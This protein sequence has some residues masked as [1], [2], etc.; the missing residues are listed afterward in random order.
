VLAVRLDNSVFTALMVS[1]VTRQYGMSDVAR[2]YGG[3][4]MLQ[5]SVVDMRCYK[6]VSW[7]LDGIRR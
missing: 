5:D 2:Q 4:Q 6:T 1:D 3:Y 7:I